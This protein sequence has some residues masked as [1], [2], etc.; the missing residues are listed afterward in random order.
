MKKSLLAAAVVTVGLAA[1][2]PFVTAAQDQPQT[3]GERV[4]PRGRGPGGPGGP[5][6]RG[7]RMGGPL[8]GGLRDLTDEQRTQ[9][10]AIHDKHAAQIEPLLQRVRTAREALD[11]AI[12]SGN[13]ANLQA[14][15]IEVGNAETELTF[16]QAQVQAEIYKILTPEQKQKIAERRKEMEAR[17]QEMMKRRQGQ[18]Q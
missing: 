13:I 12:I 4:G 5:M 17:R 9:V 11:N 14:L 7:G 3:Q 2:I 18:T 15:S 10:K 16:A 8:A 1:A 6:G